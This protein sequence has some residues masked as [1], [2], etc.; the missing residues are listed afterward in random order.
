MNRQDFFKLAKN[1]N[2]YRVLKPLDGELS[3]AKVGDFF[4]SDTLFDRGYNMNELIK[5]GFLELVPI[6]FP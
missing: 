4:F 5:D 6:I 1:R 3:Y 2:K